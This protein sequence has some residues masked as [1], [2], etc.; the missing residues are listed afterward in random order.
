[1]FEIENRI[2]DNMFSYFQ[3]E[4]TN[5]DMSQDY[6]IDGLFVKKES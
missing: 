5:Q 6:E 4:K 3:R 1:V 2:Y